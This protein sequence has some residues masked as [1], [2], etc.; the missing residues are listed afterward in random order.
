MISVRTLLSELTD[1]DVEAP[2]AI[3]LPQDRRLETA[4]RR[5]IESVLRET[6]GNQA[7]AAA[8]LGIARSQL[9]R[10]LRHWREEDAVVGVRCLNCGSAAEW[11]AHP[12]DEGYYRCPTCRVGFMA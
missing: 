3:P 8:I 5:H 1:L 9:A 12:D 6:Y 2:P 11:V 10:H 4:I 7:K